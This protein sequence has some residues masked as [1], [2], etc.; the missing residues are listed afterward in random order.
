ML[1]VDLF[2]IFFLMIGIHLS[3]FSCLQVPLSKKQDKRTGGVH[4]IH[5]EASVYREG[6]SVCAASAEFPVV[7]PAGCGRVRYCPVFTL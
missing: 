4:H 3:I 5:T 1:M 2:L 6:S 7:P